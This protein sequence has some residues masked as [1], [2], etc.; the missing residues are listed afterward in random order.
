VKQTRRFATKKPV[1]GMW[2]R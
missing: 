1:S 2:W